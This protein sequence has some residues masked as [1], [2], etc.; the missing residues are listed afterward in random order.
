[1]KIINP[2]INILS[3]YIKDN[4]RVKCECSV[5]GRIWNPKASNILQGKGCSNCHF[6]KLSRIKRKTT[7]QFIY[8][9]KSINPQILITGEYLGAGK[10]ISC[11]CLIHDI[12]F[13]MSPNHLL[14]NKTGCI[15]CVRIKNHLSGNKTHELFVEELSKVDDSIILLDEYYNSHS[16]AKIKCK[17]CG[18]IWTVPHVGNLLAGMYK[19]KICHK[20]HS[21]GEIKISNYLKK[22]NISYDTNKT[23]DGLYGV[24]GGRLSYDFYIGDMNLLIEYQGIQHSESIEVFGGEEQFLKQK[25]H[26]RRK[27]EYAKENNIHLVE[28]WHYDYDYIETILDNLFKNPVTTTAV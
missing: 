6:K 11:K 5:C 26:D 3:E 9:M 10:H 17:L 27:R 8:E 7:E 1:M 28:I 18:N 23:F 14:H 13:E 4:E 2:S 19:C 16:P 20:P 22:Y 24:N 25:E 21:H 15:E 12:N